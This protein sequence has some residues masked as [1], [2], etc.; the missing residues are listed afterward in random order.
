MAHSE[1][2]VQERRGAPFVF[3]GRRTIARVRPDATIERSFAEEGRVV[4]ALAAA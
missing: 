4:D 1:A 3:Y 2:L